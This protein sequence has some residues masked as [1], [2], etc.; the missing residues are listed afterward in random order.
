MNV[1]FPMGAVI[2][3]A[4]LAATPW[5]AAVGEERHCL[6]L[7]LYWEAKHHGR[8]SMIAVGFVVL[9][10]LHDDGFPHT[11][12]EVVRDGGETPPCQFSYWCD[13]QVDTPPANDDQWALA[14]DVA[15]ELLDAPPGDPTGSAL[16]F[17]AED[18]DP[19]WQVPRSPTVRIGGHVFYR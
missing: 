9:N 4:A 6:A 13:G 3:V 12:C 17:H 15:R 1:I 16:F 8:D 5:S 2:V 7:T 11:I 10:R 14:R 18:I 19:P